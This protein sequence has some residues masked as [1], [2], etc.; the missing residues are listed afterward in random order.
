MHTRLQGTRLTVFA[1]VFSVLLLSSGCG[2]RPPIVTDELRA[3]TPKVSVDTVRPSTV[4]SQD[5]E[6]TLRDLD[7]KRSSALELLKP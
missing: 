6:Q 3:P 2:S 1:I 7:L 4:I 5:V